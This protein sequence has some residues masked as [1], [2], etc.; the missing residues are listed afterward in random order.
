MFGTILLVTHGT[1]G[2][3]KV[4]PLYPIALLDSVAIEIG[5]PELSTA[6][7]ICDNATVQ[8]WETTTFKQAMIPYLQ[9]F[10]IFGPPRELES[11]LPL[12]VKTG[13]HLAKSMI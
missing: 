13:L 3:P 5:I 10:G 8:R 12:Y 11:S 1:F 2:P 6:V 7:V 4:A 9:I